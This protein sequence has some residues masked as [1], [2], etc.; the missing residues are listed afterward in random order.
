MAIMKYGRTSPKTTDPKTGERIADPTVYGQLLP[1]GMSDGGMVSSWPE[2]REMIKSGKF[3]NF[4]QSVLPVDVKNYL[5][6]KTNKLSEIYEEPVIYDAYDSP[7]SKQMSKNIRFDYK[8][9]SPQV[10]KARQERKR[11][12]IQNTPGLDVQVNVSDPNSSGEKY[13]VNQLRTSTTTTTP[14]PP[15]KKEDVTINVKKTKKIEKVKAIDIPAE[16]EWENPEPIKGYRTKREIQKSR[17]GGTDKKINPF[18]WTLTETNDRGEARRL[19]AFLVSKQ[20]E[21]VLKPKGIRYNREEKMAKSFYAPTSELGHGGYYSS[22]EGGYDEQGYRID[23]SKKIKSDVKNIRQEKRD[24][25]KQTSLTG[26]ERRAGSKLFREDIKTG[27]LASRYAKRG[28]LAEWKDNKWESG[29]KSKLKYFT[30][31]ITRNEQGA[32]TKGAM[33]GYVEAAEQNRS[34]MKALKQ[35]EMRLKSTGKSSEDNAANRNSTQERMKK[36]GRAHV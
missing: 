3:K 35:E 21:E 32:S 17:E 26:A 22:G 9:D 10:K 5:S 36:I 27:K 1:G 13:S 19:P 29:D 14:P 4:D 6:G 24:W 33:S 25:Q 31:D 12:G 16:G 34:R 15:P 11:L 8:Q 20:K 28:D 18:R 2:A 7:G 30:P 23:M